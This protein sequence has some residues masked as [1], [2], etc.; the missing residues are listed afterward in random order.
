MKIIIKTIFLTLLLQQILI[1]QSSKIYGKVEYKLPLQNVNITIAELNLLTTSNENGEYLFDKI[2]KGNY[3]I[4]FSHIGY[5]KEK[6][7]INVEINKVYKLNIKLEKKII[8]LGEVKIVSSKIEKS[9]KDISLPI[10]IV[11]SSKIKTTSFNTISDVLNKEPGISVIKDGTWATSVNVR[12]LSKQNLV[13][14]V[15]GNRI[16]TSTN[17]AAGLSLININNV[18]RIEVVKGGLSSLYGTGATGGVINIKQKEAEFGKKLYL[19]SQLISNYNSVNNGYSNYLNLQA[20]EMNWCL[21]LNGSFRRAEDTKIPNGILENSSFKDE[22]LNGNL[23]Y[24]PIENLILKIDFQKFSA[25]DVGIPGG[26]PFPM[27][28]S[29][30]YNYAKRAMYDASVTYKNISKNLIK[31]N[32]KYYHQLIS[33]AVEIKPNP[34]V[35]VK[36]NADHT[37]NGAMLQMDWYLSK[38][39]YLVTGIDYWQREYVGLREI[40][41]KVKNIYSVDKPVPNSKYSSIGLFAKDE[42]QLLNNLNIN[43]S[44]RYDFINISNEKTKNPVYIISNGIVNYNVKNELAS[45]EKNNE[46]N[47]SF[48]GSIGAIYNFSEN[49]DFVLN[50]GYNFRSPSL[51]ERYQYIDLGGI[52]YLGN[53]KL[54]TEKGLYFDTGFRIWKDD[55]NFR[56]SAFYNSFY[57]LVID[58]VFIPDSIFIKDNVGEARLY[59][60][61]AKFDYNFYKDYLFY[62]STSYVKGD[63]LR[64]KTNLPQIPPLNGIV[65]LN[66]SV[67]KLIK[68]N[69]STTYAADQ[70]KTGLGESRTGGYTYYDISFIGNPINIGIVNLNLIAGIQNIFNRKYREHLS[71]YRGINIAEPGRNIFIKMILNVK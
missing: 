30:K 71:T 67:S 46:Q 66:L 45:F 47:K 22:S 25:Y 58:N 7:E 37:T 6:R 63:D 50:F 69:L 33:R 57:N 1:C 10:E 16:E 31:T 44:G 48:S 55:L 24:S 26:S 2:P 64:E 34:N 19:K 17:I 28:A 42:V 59:G 39:N 20:G 15:D 9:L 3:T 35:N 60:L 36:P 40:N 18:E 11:D 8:R 14:L 61:E 12:G 70:N 56:F 29:A 4:I 54:K 43:L 49:Y 68:I 62:I 51:E 5:R 38:N 52:I 65:G 23:K 13:Y 27:S 21:N 53:P 32:I 41:N